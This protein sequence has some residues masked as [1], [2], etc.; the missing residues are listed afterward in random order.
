VGTLDRGGQYTQFLP[1]MARF[2][3]HLERI[4]GGASPARI[5]LHPLNDPLW[6]ERRRMRRKTGLEISTTE[7]LASFMASIQLRRGTFLNTP[8]SF[9][10]LAKKSTGQTI[11]ILVMIRLIE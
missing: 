4:G 1:L 10:C 8:T 2:W 7:Y 3:R 11:L 6:R 5:P 9:F